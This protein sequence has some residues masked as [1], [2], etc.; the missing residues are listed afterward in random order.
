MTEAIVISRYLDTVSDEIYDKLSQIVQ[1]IGQ[2][3]LK[4]S[5]LNNLTA[6]A[7]ASTSWKAN[8]AGNK[9]ARVISRT[10]RKYLLL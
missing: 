8:L 7:N 4:K 3:D 2:F 5:Q 6:A 1:Q 9:A 10:W